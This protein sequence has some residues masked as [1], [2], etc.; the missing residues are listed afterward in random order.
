LQPVRAQGAPVVSA[1]QDP[2]LEAMGL[3][4]ISLDE[5]IGRTGIAAAALQARLL[6]LE[7]A[8]VAARMPGGRFQQLVRG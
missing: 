7:L 4:P 1:A 2:L 8:G 3:E 6:E 5:L